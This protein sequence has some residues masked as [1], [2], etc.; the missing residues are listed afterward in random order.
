MIPGA[1]NAWLAEQGRGEVISS[2]PVGGG[3]INNGAVLKAADGHTFFL[4]TNNNLSLIHI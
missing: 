4:K 3:C 2:R 1:V